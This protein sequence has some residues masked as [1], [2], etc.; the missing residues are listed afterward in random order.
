MVIN[1][2]K[3]LIY[4]LMFIFKTRLIPLLTVKKKIKQAK[5][6]KYDN[7]ISITKQRI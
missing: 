2:K 7:K 3:S 4:F 1:A 5:S 6:V